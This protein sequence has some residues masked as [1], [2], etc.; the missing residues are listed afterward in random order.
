MW[1]SIQMLT[2]LF[3]KQKICELWKLKAS[4]LQFTP[5]IYPKLSDRHP[6]NQRGPLMKNLF[7]AVH[8]NNISSCWFWKGIQLCRAYTTN[9]DDDTPSHKHFWNQSDEF[10]TFKKN[11]RQFL[12]KKKSIDNEYTWLCISNFEIRENPIQA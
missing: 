9:K 12:K 6:K 4:I 2:C 10:D 11:W 7:K 8:N 5:Q 3:K 1:V